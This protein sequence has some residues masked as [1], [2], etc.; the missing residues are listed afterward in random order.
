CAVRVFQRR[1]IEY[2]SVDTAKDI[3]Q[4]NLGWRPSE[5]ITTAASTLTAHDLLRLQ[6]DQNLHEIILGNALL[7]GERFNPL[8]NTG[9]MMPS[10]SQ[11]GPRGVIAFHRKF[12]ARELSPHLAKPQLSKAPRWTHPDNPIGERAGRS[13]DG[14]SARPASQNVVGRSMPGK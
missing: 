11:Y 1:G 7:F 6:L 8:W 14:S 4:G 10:E 2:L 12:H 9:L 5:A 13:A 3:S